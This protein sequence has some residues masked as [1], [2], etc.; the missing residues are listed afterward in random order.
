MLNPQLFAHVEAGAVAGW[1]ARLARLATS[2]G[3]ETR[4]GRRRRFLVLARH[5]SREFGVRHK[6]QTVG[7]ISADESE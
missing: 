6:E 7:K 2:A 1:L 4:D 3:G 5:P